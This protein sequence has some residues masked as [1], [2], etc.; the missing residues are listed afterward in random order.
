MN[1]I[2][3]KE[4]NAKLYELLIAIYFNDLEKVIEFK[5]RYPELYAMKNNFQ[6][7]EYSRQGGGEVKNRSLDLMNLTFFNKTVWKEDSWRD[8]VSAL[9]KTLR[10][11]TEQMLD[12]WR[13]E[14]GKQD[15]Q[16]TIEYN[17]YWDCFWCENPMDTYEGWL[18][19]EE[20]YMTKGLKE[21]DLKLMY[22]SERFD[23]LE[24]KKLLELGANPNVPF[25]ENE[26][27]ST[28]LRRIGDECSFLGSCEVLPEF[29]AYEERRFFPYMNQKNIENLLGDLIGL[30]AHE[31]MYDLLIIYSKDKK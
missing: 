12:F 17:Q 7:N 29:E 16:R 2:P 4:E 19:G 25:Y 11:K 1:K 28:A 30:A 5:N 22:Q 10:T 21:I 13:T 27:D 31:E 15:I 20:E 3:N 6:I 24:T 26:D 18:D 23:F 14:L 9:I 8:S